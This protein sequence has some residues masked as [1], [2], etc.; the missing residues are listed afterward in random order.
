MTEILD[1]EK[2]VKSQ[3][4]HLS[5]QTWHLL[6]TRQNSRF[7]SSASIP[8]Y[9]NTVLVVL[10]APSNPSHLKCNVFVMRVCVSDFQI[11]G[12][13]SLPVNLGTGLDLHGVQILNL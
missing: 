1:I 11:K 2:G 13:H 6:K 5:F 7:A 12:K 4:I 3:V 8:I 9:R 10:L